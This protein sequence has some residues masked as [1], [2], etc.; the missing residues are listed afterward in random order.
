MSDTI[1]SPFNDGYIAELFEAYRRD[2]SSV[3]ESWRQYFRLAEQLAGAPATQGAAAAAGDPDLARKAAGAA[4]LMYSI[5]TYG[6]LAVQLD[7]LGTA[8]PN[9]AELTPEFHGITE[10]ELS[11]VPGAALGFPHM[12]TAA[13]VIARLR[14]RYSRNLAIEYTHLSDETE[15]QWFRE[16]LTA[17]RLTRPL[18]AE[19]QITLLQRLT[20]V[21]GLERFIGRS[22]VGL[23]RFSIEGI[24]ALVPMLD[25]AI[26]E[27]AALGARH[28]VIAMPHRGRLNTLTNLM[29]KPYADLFTEFEGRSTQVGEAS[30]GDVKYHL[31]Y[32][33]EWRATDGTSVQMHLAANPSH[34]EIVNPVSMGMARARQRMHG[35]T[36]V[37]GVVPVSVHGD[38]AFVGEGIVPE[39][40]NL[41]ELRAYHVGGT[42][43]IIGNNQV[44]FTTNPIDGRST[45][46][47]SD[48]A[49][50]FEVPIIHVNADDAESCVI[51][52]RIAV[53][54]R[55]RFHKD[56]LVDL[57][58]YRRHGHNEGDEPGYTQPLEADNIRAH[59]SVRQLLSERLIAANVI[60]ADAS[61]Q[62][63]RDVSD[64]LQR[65]L[66]AVRADNASVPTGDHPKPERPANVETAVSADALHRVNEHLL[67]WP[68]EFHPHP[69]LAKQLLRR[70]EALGDAPAIDWGHAE[71]LAFGSLL[72][73]GTSIRMSGQDAERGTFSHRHAVLHDVKNGSTYTPLAHVTDGASF[74]IYNSPLS[75]MAVMAFE[76]GYSVSR[77]DTLTVW[78]AQFGDFANVA[79][80]VMDQ[81]VASDRAKWGQDSGLVLLLPHGY[82]GAGPEHSSARLERFLQLCAESNLRVAYPT[83]PAQYFHILR[84]QAK[85]EPR[86]P[87]VLMQPK[88]MLRL[89]SAMSKLDDLAKGTF[90]TVIDDPG[91]AAKRDAVER[92]VCCTG[93]IYWE[94]AAAEQRPNVAVVRIEE[95]YPWPKNALES[96]VD[97]YPNVEQVA[98]VQEEPKNQGAWTHVAPLLRLSAGTALEMPYIGRP[99]RASPAEGYKED[100]DEEQAR[101]IEA[102][103]TFTSKAGGRRG[104]RTT[105]AATR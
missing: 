39:T 12:A 51:A 99:E 77:A 14:F 8:P 63:E 102:A 64:N 90:Q 18:A 79:Q 93:K 104:G 83:T 96:I 49:K 95:L 89:A 92:V 55:H 17:E 57:V 60:S 2:P 69:R 87:L 54:Y 29:G 65:I 98:W 30:T 85:Q 32:E 4:G 16:L 94:I 20:Q 13:D 78:E 52:M 40:F 71:A 24:D 72:L 11:Q 76:Y 1:T 103:L 6:H 46:Y 23:K 74:E 67:A 53:A 21:E 81:F 62:M 101:I 61:A 31:G 5:R 84:R 42:L 28:I 48:T 91:G 97:A 7:P 9:A 41:S 15:R 56:F 82:E 34:L 37:D 45:H 43:H 3:D 36:D 22:Y 26:S 19:Q 58:G 73:D 25:T 10:A 27:S 80:P 70:R 33:G 88:W 47:A 68:A 59:K 100:H 38:A 50:G 35:G 86:R 66:D 44:G 75:E 105:S